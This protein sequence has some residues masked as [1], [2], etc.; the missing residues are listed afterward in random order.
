MR[1]ANWIWN[2]FK[3]LKKISVNDFVGIYGIGGVGIMSLIALKALGIK[4]IYAVDKNKKIYYL[5]K[6]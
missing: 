5:L 4:N 3:F 1:S 2:S 6:D